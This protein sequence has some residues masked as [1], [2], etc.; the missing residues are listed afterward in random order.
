M[1][2]WIPPLHLYAH[3]DCGYYA[4]ETAEEAKVLLVKDVGQEMEPEDASLFVVVDDDERL[5][6]YD[7]DGANPETRTAG[8]WARTAT[9]KGFQFGGEQ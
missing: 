8:E 6:I 7:E 4:A 5:K 9:R 2:T 1:T 3:P